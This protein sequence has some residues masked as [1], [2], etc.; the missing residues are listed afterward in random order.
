MEVFRS[1]DPREREFL[2]TLLHRLYGRFM[3]LRPLLYKSIEHAFM[4]FI[5]ET[6]DEHPGI[7]DILE[8]LRKILFILTL[9]LRRKHH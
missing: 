8:V 2:K 6:C 3:V 1:E 4:K 7:T 5:Y 9:F